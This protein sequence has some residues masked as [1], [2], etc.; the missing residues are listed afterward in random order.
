MSLIKPQEDPLAGLRW[1][2]DLGQYQTTVIAGT[3]PGKTFF[4]N[5][6]DD[7]IVFD[8]W[9]IT[10]V[11]GLGLTSNLSIQGQVGE[12]L[13]LRDLKRVGSQKC[14]AWKLIEKSSST[15][16][17]QYCMGES[18]FLNRITIDA[19]GQISKIEQH[20]GFNKQGLN[21][22]GFKEQGSKELGDSGTITL[23]KL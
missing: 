4:V 18:R 2:V 15:V 8:G 1:R 22:Q 10:E 11:H 19:N 7:L 16:Q 23:T 5:K 20:F 17:E 12:R 13:I 6:D 21:G 3:A 9:M 14:E